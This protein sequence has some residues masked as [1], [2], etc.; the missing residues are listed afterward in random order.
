MTT[1]EE[2]SYDQDRCWI[3]GA[4]ASDVHEIARGVHRKQALEE[5]CTW[6]KLCREC[7]RNKVHG[8]GWWARITSQLALKMVRDAEH[9]DRQRVNEIRGRMPDAITEREVA[10]EMEE[11][12]RRIDCVNS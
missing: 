3:C 4:P 1:R 6:L 5:R 11:L 7:H 2:F 9:Y 8:G 12:F 10:L